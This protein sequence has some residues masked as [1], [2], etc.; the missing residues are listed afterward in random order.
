MTDQDKRDRDDEQDDGAGR[1]S[2]PLR[3]RTVRPARRA[4]AR[5]ARR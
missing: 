3:R 2:A 5:P 4:I 1:R